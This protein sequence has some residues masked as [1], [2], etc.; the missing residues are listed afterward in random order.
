[1]ASEGLATIRLRVLSNFSLTGLEKVVSLITS[2]IFEQAIGTDLGKAPQS[3]HS[4]YNH[5][6]QADWHSHHRA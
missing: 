6:F 1:M 2:S 3:Q 5:R 4:V